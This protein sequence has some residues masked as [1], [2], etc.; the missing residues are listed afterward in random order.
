MI[1]QAHKGVSTENPEN[2]MPAFAA[3]VQQGYKIIEL[4]T[5][6]TKDLQVVLLHDDT[7]N[8]TARQENGDLIA[9]TV[10]ISDITYEEALRYDFGLWFSPKF[11]GT[12]IPLFEDVLRFA[13]Q[14]GVKLKIDNKFQRFSREQKAVFFELL[15][16]YVDVA[17]LTCSEVDEIKSAYRVF[18]EMHFHYDGAV[19]AENLEQL[20]AFLPKEQ[21][22]V[23]LPHKNP[24]TAWVTVDFANAQLAALVKQYAARLGVWILSESSHLEEAEKLGA[25]VIE[26]NGQLKPKQEETL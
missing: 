25:D 8:R 16:P 15:K 26:T 1:F 5:A 22:T 2:T 17:C 9:D 11:K 3:A 7:I 4:D 10:N 23:W 6:V 24:D 19:T 21:L 13:Q 18:P 14:N 20:R 12:K